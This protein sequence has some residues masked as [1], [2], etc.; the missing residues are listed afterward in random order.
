MTARD[1]ARSTWKLKPVLAARLHVERCANVYSNAP[2]TA[3]AGVGNE[4]YNTRPTCQ[5]LANFSAVDFVLPLC[6]RGSRIPPGET[7]YPYIKSIRTNVSRL[8]PDEGLSNRATVTIKLVDEAIDD[9]WLDPY[10][11][12]RSVPA[13]STFWPRFMARNKALNGKF[14]ELLRGYDVDPWDWST[15]VTELYSID[16]LDGPDGRSEMKLVLKD[17]VKLADTV[18]LPRPTRGKLVNELFEYDDIGTAQA[19]GANTITLHTEASAVDDFYNGMAVRIYGQTGSGQERIITDYDGAGRVATVNSDW[20]VNPN[21]SSLYFVQQLSITLD[22][23]GTDYDLYGVPGFVRVGKEVIRFSARVGEVLSWPD[24][25]YRAQ[26][27]T[28]LE[29]HRADASVQICKAFSNEAFTDVIKWF[30]IESGLDSIYIDEAGFAELD[31]TWLGN[32]YIID[33]VAISTPRKASDYIKELLQSANAMTWWDAQTKLL[34]LALSVPPTPGVGIK[35]LSDESALVDGTV[36]VKTLNSARLT[37]SALYFDLQTAT[38]NV[39]EAS[40]Y[41]DGAVFFDQE[42]LV[43]YGTEQTDVQY[44]RFFNAANN[45]AARDHVARALATRRDPPQL[46]KCEIHPKDYDFQRGDYRDFLTNKIVDKA[47]Q[48][49]KTRAL[50]TMIDDQGA[51]VKIEARTTIFSRPFAA[52]APN[53]TA[54]YPN[55][56]GYACFSQNDGLMPDGVEGYLFF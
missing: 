51:T 36:D 14:V 42:A 21:N 7:Y 17:L 15:F 50:I 22:A 12:T 55:N 56:N 3:S 34:K 45:G 44:S 23:N 37:L 16:T 28:V 13:G 27:N 25:S 2:C 1:D 5:D 43:E 11:D 10:I 46:I 24:T 26:F 18:Q 52:F 49:K 6:K 35:Q 19:G 9:R 32:D 47:G 33:Q 53:G 31:S 20:A 30:Y 39:R 40:N 48:P 38:S 41:L 29:D 54:N 8:N 4:C